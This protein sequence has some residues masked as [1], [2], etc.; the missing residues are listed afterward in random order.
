V[1]NLFNIFILIE[2]K[3]NYLHSTLLGRRMEEESM[4]PWQPPGWGCVF[5]PAKPQRGKNPF[6]F[7][8]VPC[9]MPQ[10][11]ILSRAI[12]LPSENFNA[13]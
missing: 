6:I 12:V 2:K 10:D 8:N 3:F 7:L 13:I 5:T 11:N 4:H 1:K 9:K